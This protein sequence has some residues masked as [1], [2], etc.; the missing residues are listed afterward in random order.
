MVAFKTNIPN[1]YNFDICDC[2]SGFFTFCHNCLTYISRS[3]EP[4][5]DIFNKMP[6]LYYQ[7][8][9]AW[10]KDLI[11]VEKDAIARIYLV[12]SILK[13]K[14]KNNFNLGL[15]ESV[16]GYFVL[17]PLNLEPLLILL[18]LK[19]TCMNNL[20]RIVW[21]GKILPQPE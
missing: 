15:Y 19:T 9:F 14:F 2:Y 4:K 6:Q 8:Y 16:C 20:M 21:A 18:S 10:L 11:F 13:L 7:Y 12:I 17:L 3:R 5:F 1:C